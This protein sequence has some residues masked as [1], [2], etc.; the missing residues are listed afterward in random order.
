M[1]LHCTMFPQPWIFLIATI[2]ATSLFMSSLVESFPEADKVKSLPE[3]SPLVLW[4]NGVSIALLPLLGLTVHPLELEPSQNMVLLLQIKERLLRKIKANI[5]YLESPAGVGFSYSLNFP[6]YKTLNNEVTARDSL[7]FL[8]RWFAKF[9]EYK[10]RD[11]YI[12]GESY[13]GNPLL[14]FDTDMNAVDEYYWSHGIITDYAYKI[15]TSLCNSSRVLRE[16]FGGQISKDCVL[17]QLKKSQKCILLQLSL[18]HSMLL[19]RN[20]GFLREMLNSGMFQ[21]KK[22]HNVLQTEEPD[23]QVDECNLKY[24]EMYLNRKDVQKALHARLDYDPLNREI[25]TIN[26]VGFFVLVVIINLNEVYTGDQDSVIPCMGTRR[27]VDRLAKTLGL[28]T[29]VP[30]SSWFVDKQVGGWTQ[31][32]GNHLTYATVRGAS[33]GTPVTQGHMAP[34]LKLVPL[35]STRVVPFHPIRDRNLRLVDESRPC[36][37]SVIIGLMSFSVEESHLGLQR[38]VLR[39]F[40]LAWDGRTVEFQQY[41][42]YVT[43]DDQHQRALFYYFVEAEEDPASKP[44]VLWLNGGPGCSSIGV[45][46]FAEHGPFRPSDNNVLQQ[47]DY[48]WNKVANVLYLESPAGVGFSYSSN[49]SFY[50]SV[51]DEITARDNLVFLQRWFTKFPEYSNNDFFI[52]GESYGG[53]YV[54]Q[55]SQLIVQTKTN[56]N[57]KGIAIGNPLLE[58]NTDFNSRSEYFWSHGLISD[59]TYEVLTRVCNFSSIRRQIQNG[60]LRGVCVKANKLL[61]TEISNFIDKYDVTL[62]VCLSSVNQQA[63][64]LNQLQETQKIDVCIGDKTT[65]YLNRKQVQKALHANL[66]GVTKWSTCSSVLHYDYQ[67]LEIPTIPILGSLVKSGIKVLVYSGD[68]D[69]VIPLI[70][71]RSLVNGLAKEIGLDTTVAYRAWFEGKQV[72]GWTKVYGN[73]LSY[74]TIRGASHE[75]PFSQ[76][77]RSLLLLKAFLEG[78]PL[79]GSLVNSSIRVLVY[80]GDQDSVIPLLGS[81]SLVN[82]LAKQLGLNTTVAYRAWFEGKQ[83]GG[84]TQVYGDILSYATIRGASHEAPYTQ[85]ERSLGLLKAFLEGKPLPTDKISNL[86]GQPHVKFQ[87]YSGYFSVDNQNQ[88]ALFYYFVEAEKHPTSKPVVLWLNGGPGCS[89]IGV[90]A[91]VEHGPFKPDSNVLVKNHFSW[92]KVANVLYLESPAGVGFSYSSNASFYTLVTDEIT[93]RDNLVFLQRWFTEFPEYSNNDFFIT[94]ES[95]AGH[96]APQLAQLIVQT[97]TNFNLKGIAIGN[98]LMEFDTDLNSKA[99]FL[100]SHGLISDSTYDLFTRVCN[101]STIRRQTIHGNLSDVCAKINGLVFTEVSNYIDQYD[102]TLDVCLSSANQQSYELNQMQETQKIDVCVDDKAV[103]YLNRKDVQKAL[104]AKLVGVSKWSTCSRVLHYD[105]RNLEIPTI[106]I[107]GALVNSNI[108]VLV[109]SGDQDSVI[110]LLGSRSLVNGLAKELGLNTT[111]AYRAWFEGKQVAGWTQVY[112]GM[113][114][115]AT[116]RGASHEAPFTQPQ[117]SLVLLKAFLEGKPLPGVK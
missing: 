50:A 86:P 59:S 28:K 84:W 42:G 110:P 24:S 88:R 7:V 115:Y 107:L 75:A 56:F 19:G 76:P 100:W 49:K 40:H 44:L 35:P 17:L 98:P 22:S 64:V 48:S 33:H 77:Q 68:Q 34:C 72:A 12:M 3:Q 37:Q 95:Y 41:S 21:F 2:F 89:S 91:L 90:G 94:G 6:F 83:V 27:L 74:A 103:T 29:T 58:F 57:L 60:N 62:D 31:V 116:I 108:R 65:T 1:Q 53:H 10:N 111:V 23:Q 25:P 30:Y 92:N 26:V 14:D 96:Y 51:T 104:H 87:Q 82:G 61:N 9:P 73:I 85:P 20:A 112:G 81:R 15:M 55:L 8:Q 45:G 78:K 101:Y 102:V 70:G 63:Y 71:S 54:P 47:N 99:E 11:F 32:Y 67:N 113:L 80:S 52:T 106:S 69:S 79:P 66:V 13:G 117:R 97:K 5:L 114:S 16:Y 4:L 109:Y 38:I 93:A 105:R 39:Q 46:A 36:D 18:T 43:V